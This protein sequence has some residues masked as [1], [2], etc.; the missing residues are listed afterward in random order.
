MLYQ[1]IYD[2]YDFIIFYFIRFYYT[3]KTYA[4]V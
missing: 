1:I 2:L 4:I 3:K